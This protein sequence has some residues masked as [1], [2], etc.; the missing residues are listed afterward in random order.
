[1]T[2][3]FNFLQLP[4]PEGSS[5]RAVVI[6]CSLYKDYNYEISSGSFVSEEFELKSRILN[7]FSCPILEEIFSKL[8]PDK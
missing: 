6:I 5:L 1:M 4:I 8:N 2:K 7:F 3:V